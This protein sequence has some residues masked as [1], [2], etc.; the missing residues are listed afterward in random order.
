MWYSVMRLFG[1]KKGKLKDE[2]NNNRTF[3]CKHC[4]MKFEDKDRLKI[5]NK[6]AHSGKGE[7]KKMKKSW[8][9]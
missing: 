1:R 2:G 8:I 4:E 7:K 3:K 6:K 5:H 9:A